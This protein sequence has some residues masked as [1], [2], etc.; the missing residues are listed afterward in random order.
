MV[1]FTGLKAWG[2][3]CWIRIQFKGTFIVLLM[4]SLSVAHHVN[5]PLGLIVSQLGY[6]VQYSAYNVWTSCTA[7]IIQINQQNHITLYFN[8]TFLN[9]HPWSCNRLRPRLLGN[10]PGEFAS[11]PA[12]GFQKCLLRTSLLVSLM[13]VWSGV[14]HSRGRGPSSTPEAG[15]FHIAPCIILVGRS[16]P[17]ETWRRSMRSG[18][19][20]PA[21][22]TQVAEVWTWSV[23]L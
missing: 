13:G 20:W 11:A 4:L 19:F 22:M 18:E 17:N 23:L 9:L 7:A 15:M 10:R 21:A 8:L 16:L 12:H 5:H 2:R 1:T 3:D 6:L 14:K